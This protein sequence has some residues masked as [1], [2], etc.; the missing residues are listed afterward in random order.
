MKHHVT[1]DLVNGILYESRACGRPEQSENLHAKE[2]LGYTN[3]RNYPAAWEAVLSQIPAPPRKKAFNPDT[4]KTEPV[5]CWNPL[6]F[7]KPGEPRQPLQKCTDWVEEQ[8]IPALKS[9]GYIQRNP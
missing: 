5:K 1:S 7:Y 9:R 6:A 8:A 3:L 2:L 4:M